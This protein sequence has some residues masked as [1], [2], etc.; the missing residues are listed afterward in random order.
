MNNFNLEATNIKV[1][2][3]KHQ[4]FVFDH[5]DATFLHKYP[6]EGQI[7]AGLVFRLRSAMVSKGNGTALFSQSGAAVED[8]RKFLLD[9]K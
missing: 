8:P 9:R 4:V 5:F 7:A 1:A 3:L 6:T 2:L